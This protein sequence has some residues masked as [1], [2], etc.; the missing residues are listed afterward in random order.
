MTHNQRKITATLSVFHRRFL[1][2]LHKR[3]ALSLLSD[4]YDDVPCF[5]ELSP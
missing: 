3:S 1:D 5:V 2:Y 4:M